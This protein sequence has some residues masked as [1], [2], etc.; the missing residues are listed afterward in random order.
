MLQYEFI[1]KGAFSGILERLNFLLEVL[2]GR[3]LSKPLKMAHL[4][5]VRDKSHLLIVLDTEQ[6]NKLVAMG[7]LIPIFKICGQEGHIEDMVVDPEYQGQGIAKQMLEMLCAKARE[8][9]IVSLG[10][11]SHP[12][13]EAA[14]AL[15]KSFGFEERETNVYHMQL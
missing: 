2:S 13:R 15:Y 10:L 1:K 9:G 3:P 12:S 4:F 7:T 8:I 11:T 5:D 6:D 14:N